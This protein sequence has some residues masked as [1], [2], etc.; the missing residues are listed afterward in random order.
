MQCT[1]MRAETYRLFEAFGVWISLWCDNLRACI[2]RS[3][4]QTEQAQLLLYA[5]VPALARKAK[6]LLSCPPGGLE[7]CW[8]PA[9][10]ASPLVQLVA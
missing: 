7:G 2:H 3:G 4:L 1:V 10:L 5:C 8:R 6:E 9:T